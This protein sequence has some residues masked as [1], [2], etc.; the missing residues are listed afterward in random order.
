[1]KGKY[2]NTILIVALIVTLFGI[3]TGKYLFV[4]LLIPFGF[5]WFKKTDKKD[6]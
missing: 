6:K 5:S 3:I 1:M 4:F 2:T